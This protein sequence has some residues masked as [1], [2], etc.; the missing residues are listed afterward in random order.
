[1]QGVDLVDHVDDQ[2]FMCVGDEAGQA[3]AVR[4]LDHVG[5]NVEAEF[6]LIGFAIKFGRGELKTAVGIAGESFSYIAPIP[7]GFKLANFLAI[8]GH[9]DLL[10]AFPAFNVIAADNPAAQDA[11]FQAIDERAGFHGEFA[12]EGD[13][14]QLLIL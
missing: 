14:F 13:V 2:G 3:R 4:D 12:G 5:Q 7:V 8:T 6:L 10:V 9:E 11:L 1:M